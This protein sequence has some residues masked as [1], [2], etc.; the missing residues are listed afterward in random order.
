[1]ENKD[2]LMDEMNDYETVVLELDNG[3]EE[4][5]AILQSFEMEG[6]NYVLLALIK[7]DAV[8]EDAEEMLFMRDETDDTCED[9][10]II[11]TVIET[12]DE[13]NKVVDFYVG[14]EE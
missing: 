9:G 13:Y 12:D 3:T 10:E 8:S 11:L 7:D 2:M 1:M 4:E 14:E 5:F 6:K